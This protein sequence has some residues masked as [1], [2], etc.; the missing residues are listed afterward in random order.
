L[1]TKIDIHIKEPTTSKKIWRQ[2]AN[3]ALTPFFVAVP[4]ALDAA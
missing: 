1:D 4:A 2:L 3:L